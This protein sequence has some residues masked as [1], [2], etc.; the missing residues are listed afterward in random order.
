MLTFK[1]KKII[2]LFIFNNELNYRKRDI[3]ISISSYAKAT[4]F[5]QII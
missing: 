1:N 3:Y 5:K 4:G 2:L